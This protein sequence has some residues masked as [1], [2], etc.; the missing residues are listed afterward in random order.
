MGVLMKP[1]PIK[2]EIDP[3]VELIF[4]ELHKT[5]GTFDLTKKQL[6]IV[7]GCSLSTID[8]RIHLGLNIPR[9]RKSPEG[10]SVMFPILDI[11]KFI[12]RSNI[13]EVYS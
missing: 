10:G 9:Y 8:K 13:I 5:Y 6:G 1:K 11:A 12:V 3:D 4:K 7:L 2:N